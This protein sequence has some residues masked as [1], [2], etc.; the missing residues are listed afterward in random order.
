MNPCNQGPESIEYLHAFSQQHDGM[1]IVYLRFDNGSLP[2]YLAGPFPGMVEAERYIE[3]L[4]SRVAV[5]C[6]A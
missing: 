6:E 5:A 2:K 1:W 4:R 3:S